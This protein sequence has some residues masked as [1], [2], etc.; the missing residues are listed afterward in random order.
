MK[1]KE[2]L[3]PREFIKRY[4]IKIDKE[5]SQERFDWE[6]KKEVTNGNK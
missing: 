5:K 3:S 4:N 1:N 6:T 2:K